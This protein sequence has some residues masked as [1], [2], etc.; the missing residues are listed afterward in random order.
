MVIFLSCGYA[1]AAASRINKKIYLNESP[2]FIRTLIVFVLPLQ[3]QICTI[4]LRTI[5]EIGKGNFR[6]ER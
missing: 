1:A 5:N 3:K 6:K 2:P 4:K